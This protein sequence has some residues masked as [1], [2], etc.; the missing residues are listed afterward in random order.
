MK[1]SV[2]LSSG[3]LAAT[4]V[5][6][7]TA[8]AQELASSP[9]SASAATQASSF[10][11]ATLDLAAGELDPAVLYDEPGDGALWARG[12]TWKASFGPSGAV[13]I[14]R[15]GPQE[16]RSLPQRLSP[17]FVSVGGHPLAFEHG[18][19]IS[20]SG[21]RVE[22]DRGSFVEAYEL[23]AESAEQLFVFESLPRAGEL[24]LRIPVESELEA[25]D[26]AAGVEFRTATGR[27]TYSKAVAIDAGGRRADAPT[28]VVDGSIEIRV[29]ADFLAGARMPLVIDPVLNFVFVDSQ[30]EFD[31][32][33]LDT[34]FDTFNGV[35]LVVYE[36]LFSAADHDILVKVYGS[37][38]SFIA[39]GSVDLTGDSWISPRCANH[40]NAHQFLTVAGVTAASNGARTVKGRTV[41]PNGTIVTTGSQFD[42][43]GGAAGSK[44][45][46]D[47]GGDPS[48]SPG[49][50]YCVVFEHE[51]SSSDKRIGY[52]L[53]R[54]DGTL[55]GAAP[56]YLATPSGSTDDFPSVS[57]SNDG[58]TWLVAWEN[59]TFSNQGDIRAAYI[60]ANGTIHTQPFSVT[61]GFG[62]ER[63]PSASSP[64]GG[65]QR[66]AIAYTSGLMTT[67]ILVSAVAPAGVVQT[68]NLTTLENSGAQSQRQI[69][70]SVDSDG[71]HFLVSYSEFNPQ[72]SFYELFVSDLALAG[73]T[74]QLAQSHVILHP[75][76]GLSQFRSNVAAARGIGTL[77]HRYFVVY[78]I[79]QNDQ[80][81]DASG[82]FFEG[83]GG[84]TWQSFCSNDNG[85]PCPCSNN[86]SPGHGCGN[87]IFA[88]G[89]LLA[90][91]GT[92]S[93]LD[94]T[95]V[96]EAHQV[97]PGVL[98]LF[99]QGNASEAPTPVG[100]GLRCVGGTVVRLGQKI[101][102]PAGVARYPEAGDASISSRGVVPLDGGMR[103]YQT[104][105]RN[106]ANF[107]TSATF[108]LTSGVRIEW[109]R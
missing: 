79:R 35:W 106:S 30:S 3:A 97:P 92:P 8:R 38:G 25:V 94:D 26:T 107:C 71:E 64:I 54:S 88:S 57:K 98:C 9:S 89:A 49:A 50:S 42:I 11:P 65:T 78:D 84:G 14:P 45:R 95:A 39:A 77:N 23:A 109:A 28:H 90:L 73:N 34:A 59:F 24:V 70:P 32:I 20:R 12:A 61:T 69:E 81:H 58:N 93:T 47:V 101:S 82:R 6:T 53:V 31:T 80:E 27:M 15:V 102:N 67:D 17:G 10:D 68:V 33:S 74:L 44:L 66:C 48:I 46:P 41:Q 108:N 16:P 4:L 52:R 99:F 21:D 62:T 96:L 105:Y 76:L 91:S 22:M 19:S 43:S 5:L 18:A 51:F 1:L 55:V 87:S 7:S 2:V 83:F 13:F 56:T 104:W 85:T 72:F 60:N 100:D 36:H 103:T 40:G 86:G 75:M 37:T 63:F 29:G